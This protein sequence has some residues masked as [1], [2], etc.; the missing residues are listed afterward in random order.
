ME[1]KLSKEK[2]CMDYPL[3]R[4]PAPP[5]PPLGGAPPPSLPDALFLKWN[6][7]LSIYE[8]VSEDVA[9]WHLKIHE[10]TDQRA[11]NKEAF[12]SWILL[13]KSLKYKSVRKPS[14]TTFELYTLTENKAKAEGGLRAY[15]SPFQ[16]GGFSFSFSFRSAD[17]KDLFKVQYRVYEELVMFSSDLYAH[18]L[19]PGWT[20]EQFFRTFFMNMSSA[21]LPLLLKAI[22]RSQR[23]KFRRTT[24][25]VLR[26]GI[27]YTGEPRITPKAYLGM[28]VYPSAKAKKKLYENRRTGK[29]FT[30]DVTHFRLQE[31]YR[32]SDTYSRRRKSAVEYAITKILLRQL[33][34]REAALLYL[35]VDFLLASRSGY[36]VIQR[37][38]LEG[39]FTIDGVRPSTQWRNEIHVG[40]VDPSPTYSWFPKSLVQP[41]DATTRKYSFSKEKEEQILDWHDVTNGDKEHEGVELFF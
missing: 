39:G 37:D 23:D 19:S 17:F 5:P 26:I 13:M 2:R 24:V 20:I 7:E 27:D 15:S 32:V 1:A 33:A 11:L 25:V 14:L 41:K 12:K 28:T 34:L 22:G 9:L 10:I 6:E 29:K 35:G 3:G 38:T 21:Q 8:M 18:Y 31:Y 4:G 36:E 16:L 30:L 40:M